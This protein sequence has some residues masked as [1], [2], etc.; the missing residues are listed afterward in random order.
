M[1][2]FRRADG[3]SDWQ[4]MR[5]VRSV[6]LISRFQSTKIPFEVLAQRFE[7]SP[8]SDVR[9]MAGEKQVTLRWKADDNEFIDSYAIIRQNGLM[10]DWKEEKGTR[11]V[12]RQ[13]PGSDK[14]PLQE[15]SGTAKR[16][17]HRED[18]TGDQANCAAAKLS[19]PV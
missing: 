15:R 7:V 6:D 5:E 12:V 18:V 13:D 4:D 17:V 8:P 3:Q 1:L 19:Q 10:G 2:Y 9:V 14:R 11:Y 16:P